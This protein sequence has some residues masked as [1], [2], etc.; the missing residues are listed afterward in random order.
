MSLND[1]VK[2]IWKTT[3]QW[4]DHAHWPKRRD[5]KLPE[6]ESGTLDQLTPGDTVKVKFGARWYNAEV[7]ESWEPKSKRGMYFCVCLY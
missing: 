7:A 3:C 1:K 5:I 6:S 4:R 2:I